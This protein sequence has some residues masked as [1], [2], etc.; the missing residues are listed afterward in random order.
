VR[1]RLGFETKIFSKRTMDQLMDYLDGIEREAEPGVVDLAKSVYG[2]PEPYFT[3]LD[4]PD[5]R[6]DSP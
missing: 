4:E 5:H 6:L 1:D 3:I 2:E